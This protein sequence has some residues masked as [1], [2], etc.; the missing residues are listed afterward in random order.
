MS[1]FFDKL[2]AAAHR[3]A[4]NVS[5]EFS[6]AAQEQKVREAY[7]ALGKLYYQ[8]VQAGAKPEGPAF[9]EQI[10]RAGES[11]K[12]IRELRSSKNVEP[13]SDFADI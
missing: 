4:D 2:G 12:R 10:K 6:I 8:S 9:D 7:L 3:V 1:D 13:E 5:A 11:L